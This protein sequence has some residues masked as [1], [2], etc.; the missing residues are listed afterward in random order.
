[1][2]AKGKSDEKENAAKAKGKFRREAGSGDGEGKSD[3]KQ[4]AATAKGKSVEKEKG[5]AGEGEFKEKV[6]AR[7][8]R[9][10]PPTRPC[11]G[12][13]DSRCLR[14]PHQAFLAVSFET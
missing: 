2:K 3:E 8:P 7:R 13:V 12:Q 6:F 14:Q 11:N 9:P 5:K 1:M 4:K 10:N